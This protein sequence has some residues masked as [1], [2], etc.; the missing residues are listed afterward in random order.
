MHSWKEPDSCSKWVILE[1]EQAQRECAPRRIQGHLSSLRGKGSGGVFGMP[2]YGGGSQLVLG[3][4]RPVHSVRADIQGVRP[5]SE[6]Q[7][8]RQ[9]LWR[10]G[11]ALIGAEMQSYH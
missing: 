3:G 9:T 5:L 7:G 8:V 1:D 4:C 6:V 11:S 10:R 2:G